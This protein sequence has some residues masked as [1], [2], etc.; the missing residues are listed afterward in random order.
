MLLFWFDF[1]FIFAFCLPLAAAFDR[2]WKAD[3]GHAFMV[4][5]LFKIVNNREAIKSRWKILHHSFLIAFSCSF[6]RSFIRTRRLW[7]LLHITTCH[8]RFWFISLS[9]VTFFTVIYYFKNLMNFHI[10]HFVFNL[11]GTRF[12][13]SIR[14]MFIHQ[15]FGVSSK[16]AMWQVVS[17][18]SFWKLL[19][20]K[21]WNLI[22]IQIFES[23][24]QQ[25]WTNRL[26]LFVSGFF[27]FFR[28]NRNSIFKNICICI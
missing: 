19:M 7:H 14:F 24:Q 12:F 27:S 3:T 2:Q 23:L 17:S 25:N 13:F 22:T 5:L 18:L 20:N 21:L 28:L 26:D 10:L 8:P 9:V 1:A 11:I 15:K 6:I 4:L 16:F